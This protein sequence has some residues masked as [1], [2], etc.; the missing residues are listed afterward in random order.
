MQVRGPLGAIVWN[1]NDTPG[2]RAGCV[3]LHVATD[4]T[5]GLSGM[6]SG[7]TGQTLARRASLGDDAVLAWRFSCEMFW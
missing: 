7:V 6:W 1:A 3:A 5:W 2:S 4:P